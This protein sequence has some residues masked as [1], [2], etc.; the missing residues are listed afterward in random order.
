[1]TEK[2]KWSK[3]E[4]IV[5]GAGLLV[6]VMLFSLWLNTRPVQA[7]PEDV[8]QSGATAD[9]FTIEWKAPSDAEVVSYNLYVGKRTSDTQLVGT[10]PANTNRAT[11]K[12]LTSGTA[13]YIK[14]T[15]ME[16]HFSSQREETI[17]N[18]LCVKTLPGKVTG[19][20]I[21]SW[22]YKDAAY[23]GSV[24][25]YWDGQYPENSTN[26]EWEVRNKKNRIV[27]S[28][29][30]QNATFAT[31]SGISQKEILTCKVRAVQVINGTKY[32]GQWSD[33]AYLFAQPA[34]TKCRVSGKKLKLSWNK[35]SGSSGYDVYVSTKP[36][37]GYKKV[38]SVSGSKKSCT[39]TK[40]AG[41][42][43]SPKKK[44]YVYVVAKRKSGGKTYTSNYY[45]YWNT[46]NK[47]RSIK[48]LPHTHKLVNY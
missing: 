44:Y 41:K 29:F 13:R 36:N 9:S 28:G 5:K 20:K 21:D 18:G 6:M 17:V 23:R 32:Y 47:V 10:Y 11:V 3:V 4:K 39:V 38:K 27:G 25:F 24:K 46:R 43:F 12:G 7:M 45:Y 16:K 48:N 31:A 26:Y 42:K 8:W 40:F 37:S 33:K 22:V 15:Y 19:I 14:L 34:V 1:M 35:I 30:E 2:I